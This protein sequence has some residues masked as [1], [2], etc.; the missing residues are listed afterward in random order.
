MINIA[1]GTLIIFLVWI[2]YL[3]KDKKI[4]EKYSLHFLVGITG[5]YFLAL[6]YDLEEENM[7]H[8]SGSSDKFNYGTKGIGEEFNKTEE[9][10]ELRKVKINLGNNQEVEIETSGNGR[11][12]VDY[13]SPKVQTHQEIS[14]LYYPQNTSD[15]LNLGDCTVDNSCIT[16]FSA[17]YKW[18][19][20]YGEALPGFNG[21][22]KAPFVEMGHDQCQG[23]CSMEQ[24]KV[25]ED[26][27]AYLYQSAPF[28]GDARAARPG[29]MCRSCK[30]GECSGGVCGST[31]QTRLPDH[32]NYLL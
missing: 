19:G 17:G 1:L 7:E 15:Q 25:N 4:I 10:N 32:Q 2:L 23:G 20:G 5:L 27:K 30:V 14:K 11:L 26:T 3:N 24:F 21:D 8:K 28:E 12:P 6:Y 16:P 9:T 29:D 31:I 18:F 13:N 22:S